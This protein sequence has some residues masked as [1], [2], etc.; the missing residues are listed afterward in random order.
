[1]AIEPGV[2]FSKLEDFMHWLA[3]RNVDED[4]AL[5]NH[6]D[7]F[8]ELQIEFVKSLNVY[9]D[10]PMEEFVKVTKRMF[11]NRISELKYKYYETYRGIPEHV[12]SLSDLFM[13]E[14]FVVSDF[15]LEKYTQ[16]RDFVATVRGE[17]DGMALEVFDMVVFGDERLGELLK[18]AGARASCAY[19]SRGTIRIKTWHIADVLVAD[20]SDVRDC[21][22][23]IEGVIRSAL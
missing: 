12:E 5:M 14:T 11:D 17:L 10:L 4:K 16:S 15:D 3:W 20:V 22:N 19:K 18:L 21:I 9:G 7:I 2:A 13:T 8:G 23:E 1:M 6:D